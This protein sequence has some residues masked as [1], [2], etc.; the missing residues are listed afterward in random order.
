MSAMAPCA[1]G[2]VAAATPITAPPSSS[3]TAARRCPDPVTLSW[4]TT[5]QPA[6]VITREST[7]KAVSHRLNKSSMLSVKLFVREIRR[8]TK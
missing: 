3:R 5:A 8:G 6:S 7:A 2:R 4:R 1:A